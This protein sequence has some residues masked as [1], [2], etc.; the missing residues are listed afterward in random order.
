[1]MNKLYKIILNITRSFAVPGFNFFIAL[2]GVKFLGE[3]VWGEFIQVLL[4]I[5]LAVFI[6]NFG[7]KD[8]LVREYSQKPSSISQ[9]FFTNLIFRSIFLLLPLLLFIFLPYKTALLGI[10]LSIL[11]FIYQSFES[12]VIYYQKFLQQ[13]FS[14]IV[15]LITV[16]IPLLFINDLKTNELLSIYCLS[17]LFKILILFPK[18]EIKIRAAKFG[19]SLDQIKL[20]FPFF[21]IGLSGWLSSK[22]DLYLVNIYLPSNE[23]AKYQ[24]L[25]TAFLMIHSLAALIIY[26]YSKHIYR[27]KTLSVKK[28][29]RKLALLSFPVIVVCSI[30]I[31]ILLEFLVRINLSINYYIL[32]AISCFPIYFFIVDLL[33]FYKNKNEKKV[34][35]INFTASI[36]GLL[37]S[38][39]L[40][41]FYRI[42]GALIVVIATQYITLLIY[43][44]EKK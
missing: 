3:S 15:G 40:I 8:F 17:F 1:M 25:T 36:I 19:F 22:I 43:K 13:L 7:N 20:S 27:L 38:I 28:I 32:E 11:I 14:E 10:L 29:K 44:F 31:W 9:T 24:L 12:L 5:Y 33:V 37:L 34:V 26:P 6:A 35:Y 2:L 21:L 39:I 42:Y 16:L 18:L 23:L 4:W 30:C 41:P